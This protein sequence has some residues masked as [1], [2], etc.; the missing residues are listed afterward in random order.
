MN[1]KKKKIE[2]E[3][4][5]YDVDKETQA[6]AHN[7]QSI[8]QMAQY[9][10]LFTKKIKDPKA[11]KKQKAT[12]DLDYTKLREQALSPKSKP[13]EQVPIVSPKAGAQTERNITKTR[14]NEAHNKP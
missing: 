14:N 6:K 11:I 5:K 3:L 2:K 9:L 12:K 8:G 1:D 10:P 4:T 13:S 7:I